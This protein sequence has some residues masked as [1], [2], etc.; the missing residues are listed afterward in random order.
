MVKFN[1]EMLILAR[2]ARGLSQEE[3]AE[4]M[5]VKQGTLS[6]IENGLLDVA[7]YLQKICDTL[8]FPETFFLQEGRRF[9]INAHYYRKKIA[10]PKK[11]FSQAKAIVDIIKRNLDKLL[12]SIEVPRENLPKW[13]VSKNGSPSL[14]ANYLREF[15]RIPKGK[16]ENLTTI[17]EN[18]GILVVHVDFGSAK[19]DGLSMYTETNQAVIFLNKSMS[20]DRMRLTLA[21]ELGHLGMHF[22]KIIDTVRDVEK[23]AMEFASELLVPSVE[24]MPHLSRLNLEKLADLKRYWRISMGAILYK[25]KE[26]NLVKDNTARYLWT[27]FRKL[28]YHIQEP[29]EL[30]VPVEKP[31][32]VKEIIEAFIN[33]LDYSKPDLAKLL[34]INLD[35]FESFYFQSRVK[36]KVVRMS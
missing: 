18:N 22:A 16:L 7:D 36:F 1:S 28:N 29:I 2:E 27:Q 6:K 21:H 11:D 19:L 13:D 32:L 30:E 23:E 14:Y 26:L 17:I 8:N 10:I 35:D 5:G 25:A 24:I 15:W 12:L 31:T 3:L 33:D 34:S 4:L 9:E 20:G